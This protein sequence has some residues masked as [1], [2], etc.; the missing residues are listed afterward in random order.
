MQNM[1]QLHVH[2]HYQSV[3]EHKTSGHSTSTDETVDKSGKHI[4]EQSNE[5]GQGIEDSNY[6]EPV[7]I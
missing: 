7:A 6:S 2:D 4:S 1:E 5:A 3:T